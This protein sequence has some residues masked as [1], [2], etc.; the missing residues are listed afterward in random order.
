MLYFFLKLIIKI[1]IKV[2][3]KKIQVQN[4]QFLATGVPV[5]VV[6][7]HPNTFMDPILIALQIKQPLYFLSNGSVFTNPFTKW[8][9]KQFQMIPIYRQ[10]DAV[11]GVDKAEA[12]KKAFGK[13]FD[14]LA[15][16]GSL[17]IFPEGS[18]ITERR[19]REIK[20]GTARIAL[21]A[22]FQN[23][24][25]LNLKILPIGINYSAPQ[26]FRSEVFLNVGEPILLDTFKEKYNL[27][28]HKTVNELTDQIEQSL[29]DLIIHIPNEESDKLAEKVEIL[30]KNDLFREYQFSNQNKAEDFEIVKEIVVAIEFHKKENPEKIQKIQTDINAYFQNLKRLNISDEA[31]T[32]KDQKDIFLAIFSTLSFLILGFPLYLYGFLNNYLPYLL[33]SVIA[34]KFTDEEEWHAPIMLIAGIFTFSIFYTVQIFL[35]FYW[36]QSSLFSFIYGISLPLSGFFALYYG[37]KFSL[38]K[39]KWHLLQLFYQ[40]RELVSNLIQDRKLIIK[41]LND[42]KQS[43]LKA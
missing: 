4:S 30:F 26:K 39:E 9:W 31:F 2:F 3:Y 20:T 13:C 29:Q 37:F 14:F 19:L 28:D 40:K 21:G 5:I 42:Y 27:D 6:A 32:S 17:L 1:A 7:N 12:N 43:Y 15:K 18:S 16:K 8:L 24:F 33:P 25:K 11:E 35:S 36:F 41:E 23:D 38:F 10:K 34:E 22:E